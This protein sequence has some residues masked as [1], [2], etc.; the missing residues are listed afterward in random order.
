MKFL[1]LRSKVFVSASIICGLL[2]VLFSCKNDLQTPGAEGLGELG[3]T[4]DSLEVD[5][6]MVEAESGS[7]EITVTV[8][9]T[10]EE[11]VTVTSAELSDTDN[12]SLETEDLPLT[13]EVEGSTTVTGT[14]HPQE[15]GS[16]DATLT[17]AA[18]GVTESLEIALTGSGNYPPEVISGYMVLDDGETDVEGF[19]TQNGNKNGK[20][21]YK[22]TTGGDMYLYYVLDSGSLNSIIS[23]LSQ[24]PQQGWIIDSNSNIT[25]YT[26]ALA[27]GPDNPT[28]EGTQND[29]WNS[30]VLEVIAES[31]PYIE[32]DLWGGQTITVFYGYLDIDGDS[33]SGTSFQ[34][35]RKYVEGGDWLAIEGATGKSYVLQEDEDVDH[36]IR[37]KVT[38]KASTGIT[39]GSAVYSDAT[40]NTVESGM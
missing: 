23:R 10:G 4:A 38:P 30:P 5:F 35:Y 19:Y 20:P 25:D 12:Y 3:L 15:S 26:T 32:G 7:N 11:A 29:G 36:Y 18:E 13:L 24:A 8:T 40:E 22:R 33:E 28:P 37:V 2:I 34:W 17:V 27:Q 9:N 1:G 39:T 21:M 14:F 16:I 31:K 6:G